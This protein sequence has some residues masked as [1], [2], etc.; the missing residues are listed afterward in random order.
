MQDNDILLVKECQA[1]D[2]S[3]YDKLV[4]RYKR[5]IYQFAFQLSGSH[6]HAHEISQETFIQLY[7]SIK[8]FKGKS[9]FY[10]WLRRI[11]INLSINYLKKESRYE[12][13]HLEE[14]VFAN[15]DVSSIQGLVNNPVEEVEANELAQ[16]I[17]K[18]MELLPI[19]EKIVFILRIQQGLSYKEIAKTID[20]PIGTVMSRL[21]GARRRLRDKLKDYVI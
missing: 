19:R 9:K 11:T 8:R 20:C 5:Q 16:Q 10:T 2:K 21:N 17:K 12:H 3:A 1:G 4:Q 6:H 7:R 13:A 15:H 14:E 18:A